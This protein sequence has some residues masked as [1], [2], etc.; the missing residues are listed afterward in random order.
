MLYYSKINVE[1]VL[2]M[3]GASEVKIKLKTTE[4][5]IMY[6]GVV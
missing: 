1:L 5:K 4:K 6:I 2:F 3:S